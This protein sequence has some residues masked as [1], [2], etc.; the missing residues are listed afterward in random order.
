MGNIVFIESILASKSIKSVN[1]SS[2]EY[3]YCCSAEEKVADLFDISVHL[4][5]SHD[6]QGWAITSID[7]TD[8]MTHNAIISH[9][10]FETDVS[11]YYNWMGSNTKHNTFKSEFDFFVLSSN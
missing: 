6:A 9:M 5:L 2:L 10:I 11:Q 7:N 8:L 4:K 1:G 3:V